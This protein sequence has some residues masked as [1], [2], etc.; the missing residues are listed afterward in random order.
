MD[1]LSAWLNE[2]M[3]TLVEAAAA[4]LASEEQLRNT[5]GE[6]ITTF[7][8]AL[9][10]S[11]ERQNLMPLHAILIDW[12]EA[13]SAPTE[14]E[15]SGLLPVLATLKRAAWRTICDVE[16]PARAIE[17]LEELEQI[18]TDAANYLARLEA[19]ALIGDLQREL[20]KAQSR[21]EHLDKS[22]SDFIAVAAH[23]LK[24]PLTIIEG[25][26]NMLRADF[27]EQDHPR[28]A[29]MLSSLAGGT[30]RLREIIE[31]MIDVS[32]IDMNSL[33][34]HF[35]P[36]WINRLIDMVDFDLT[37]AIRQRQISLAIHRDEITTKPTFGDPERL[38]QVFY[39]V[40]SNAVKY[41][42]D[43]GT[44]TISGREMSGFT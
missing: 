7:Y 32:L 35:Q 6:S 34:L 33:N 18:F 1:Y 23:E 2:H 4:E 11:A 3:R 5:V 24:T 44:V 36:V 39:K 15:P 40:I 13:R 27:K 19:T 22:K 14:D 9:S 43:G 20:Q 16:E 12:V 17:L 10:R 30:T 26:T 25:Y 28:V 31:D 38:H 21:V 8:E 41:T 37:D 29:L 42:P